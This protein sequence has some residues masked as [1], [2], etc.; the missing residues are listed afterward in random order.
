MVLALERAGDRLTS[1]CPTGA[2]TARPLSTWPSRRACELA[3]VA[4]GADRPAADYEARKRSHLDTEAQ[5]AAGGLQ[6]VP[7]VAEARGGWAPGAQQAWTALAQ[8]IST[9]TGEALSLETDRL[10]QALAL[11]LQ[12]ENARA[13]LR[14]IPAAEGNLETQVL[15]NP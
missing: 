7:L 10:H 15:P 2:F 3:R 5:C 13:V 1:G 12:R 11:T 14:R 8:A 9:R 6:F 4:A